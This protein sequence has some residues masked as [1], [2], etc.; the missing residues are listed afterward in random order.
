VDSQPKLSGLVFG[1]R[2][3]GAVLHSSNES[4]ELS[5]WL[6]HDDSTVNIVLELLLFIYLFII[7]TALVSIN[8]V[9]LCQSRLGDRLWAG[10]PSQCITS[11]PGQL[12]LATRPWIDTMSTSES[13]GANRHTARCTVHGLAVLDGIWLRATETETSATQ[14]THVAQEA[15]ALL[16]T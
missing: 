15:L 10:K 13:W 6:C 11:H 4:G 16:F 7:I 14:W 9:A 5:Q 8:V 12:S 2:P 3:L 1:R